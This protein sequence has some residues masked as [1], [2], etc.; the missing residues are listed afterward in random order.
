MFDWEKYINF[1]DDLKFLKNKE[2][3]IN[4]W[5]KYGKNENRIYF[6][7]NF[8]EEFNDFDWEKYINFYDDLKYLKNKENAINHWNKYGKNENRIY[9]KIENI[10]DKINFIS[11]IL[12]INLERSI[13]RREYMEKIL[14]TI[15]IKNTRINAI[16]GKNNDVSNIVKNLKY[17]LSNYEIACTLSHIKAINYL[18]DLKGDYF[19]ISEDDISFD[20][21]SLINES[22]ETIIKN[23]PKFDILMIHK[24][25]NK[26]LEE[27]YTN[28]IDE[29]NKSLDYSNTIWS[30]ASYIISRN[31]INKIIK[32]AKYINDKEFIF[33]TDYLEIA[34]K[35]LYTLCDTYVY[36]YNFISTLNKDSDIHIDHLDVHIKSTRF[37]LNVIIEDFYR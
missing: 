7:I 11:H 23:C 36:K 4:H 22:L 10:N 5:N 35:Y 19:M 27:K 1:Y 18:K 29:K 16:D 14:S 15:N 13:N 25:Y 32:N 24:I 17:K 30:T 9:F 3:A 31:G 34:D 28:W 21:L 26:S 2:N 37:Q 12:W 20:N 33:N 8:L 6:T